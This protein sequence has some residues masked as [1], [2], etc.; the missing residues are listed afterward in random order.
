VSTASEGAVR[1]KLLD[2]LARIAPEI[3]PAALDPGRS[4]R[5]QADLDSVSIMEL[6]VAIHRELGV[7]VPETDYR[8]LDT[9]DGAVRYLTARLTGRAR[10]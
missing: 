4:L 6:V 2:M 9:L 10:P 8:E 1:S 7:D 3:E 5:V